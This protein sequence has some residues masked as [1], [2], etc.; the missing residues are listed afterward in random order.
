MFLTLTQPILYLDSQ[1]HT[2]PH[3]HPERT[4]FIFY[5]MRKHTEYD[6]VTCKREHD[7]ILCGKPRK[8]YVINL[9]HS[10]L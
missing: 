5:L 2:H 10:R 8:R 1:T 7:V 4:R 6:R 3:S 9:F